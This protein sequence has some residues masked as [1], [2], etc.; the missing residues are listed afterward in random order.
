MRKTQ[1]ALE[2]VVYRMTMP[3][4]PGGQGAVCEQSEWEEMERVN[5]GYHTLVRAGVT[6]EAEA[7]VLA[8]ST[9]GFVEASRAPRLKER[10]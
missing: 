10:L 8:R 7:E 4:K 5:P 9:S 2:W 6:N 1:E 3:G